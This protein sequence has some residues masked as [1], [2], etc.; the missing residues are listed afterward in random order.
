MWSCSRRGFPSTRHCCRAW[1]ALTPPFHPYPCTG[2]SSFLWHCPWGR[3]L[4]RFGTA[5]PCGARTFL[6]PL[7]ESDHLTRSDYERTSKIRIQNPGAGRKSNSSL[8]RSLCTP[9]SYPLSTDLIIYRLV[10]Q[11]VRFL[12]HCPWLVLYLNA[13]DLCNQFLDPRMQRIQSFV[14]H[15]VEAIDLLDEQ[16]GVCEQLDARHAELYEPAPGP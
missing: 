16:R 9:T 6:P 7:P 14:L 8:L 1:W 5:L 15:L 12:V 4:S 11:G 13:A 3:P 10:R 2:R